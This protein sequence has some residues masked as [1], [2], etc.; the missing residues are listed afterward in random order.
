MDIPDIG[1]GST[2]IRDIAI[3]NWL[4]EPP[5]TS[6]PYSPVTVDVGVPIVDIPGCVEAHE[7]NNKSNV[8]GNDD[9][10]GLVTYCDGNMP[11]FY[12]PEYKPNEMTFT[13]PPVVPPKLGKPEVPTP[14][15]PKT[16]EVKLPVNTIKCPTA[17][18]LA[19]EPVG[20]IFDGGRKEVTGYKLVGTQCIR[21]VRDVPIVE[22]AING[23]P[24]AGIVMTTGGIA[25]IATTSALLAKPFADILLKVIK[26]AVK[27]VV[28]KIAAIRGK[29]VPVLSLKERRDLQR[30]RTEAI[31]KLKSVL[32]PKG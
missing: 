2:E 13:G 12:A 28:K 5:V 21:E 31:R 20:F 24:P 30:E 19:K 10:K 29:K 27:K 6:I 18:Q 1:I 16:P 11:S 7:S 17:A 23:I 14:K 9:P 22:Q 8:V 26:P 15:V 32:K 4:L 3:P 25:V